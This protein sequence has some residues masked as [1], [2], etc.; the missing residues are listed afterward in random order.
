MLPVVVLV[1]MLFQISDTLFIQIFVSWD[2]E[3]EILP[4]SNVVGAPEVL[5][6]R[7]VTERV[8]F[9]STLLPSSGGEPLVWVKSLV[10]G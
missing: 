5:G 4:I 1:Q 8:Q 10:D 6:R 9:G 7:V 2:S 3:S